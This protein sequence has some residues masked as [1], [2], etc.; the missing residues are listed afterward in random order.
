MGPIVI[1]VIVV[2]LCLP[3]GAY[4]MKPKCPQCGARALR[5]ETPEERGAPAFTRC[6]ACTWVDAEEAARRAAKAQEE[7][8][9]PIRR[10]ESQERPEAPAES[11]GGKGPMSVPPMRNR[12]KPGSY[13]PPKG[14]PTR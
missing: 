5:Q 14:I 7:A 13:E 1:V 3:L 2:L 12:P 4:L 10:V 6:G 9:K 11:G 8:F